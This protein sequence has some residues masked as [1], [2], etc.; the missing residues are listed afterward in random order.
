MTTLLDSDDLLDVCDGSSM[1]PEQGVHDLTKKQYAWNKANKT[2]KKTVVT[3]VDLNALQ[4]LTNCVTPFEMC[5]KLHSVVDLKSDESL[6]SVPN[7]FFEFKWDP[8]GNI[9]LYIS[10]LEQLEYKTERLGGRIQE[11]MLVTRILFTLPKH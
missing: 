7:Q 8:V 4:L 5:Q 6:S 1:K 11:S 2:A 3:T 10:R 9:G